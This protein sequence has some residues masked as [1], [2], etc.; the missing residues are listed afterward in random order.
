MAVTLAQYVNAVGSD[1]FVTDCEAEAKEL[2]DQHIGDV[3]GVPPAI[4][5]RAVLEVGANLYQRRQ[6]QSGTGGLT[7]PEVSPMRVARDPLRPAYPILNPYL[8]PG[9]G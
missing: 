7:D 4:K 6:A 2:V 5:A 1:S 3:T 9:I 8:G